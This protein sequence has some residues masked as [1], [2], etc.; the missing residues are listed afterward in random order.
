MN[1]IAVVYSSY[2]KDVVDGLL[3]GI[4]NNS[5]KIKLEIQ[6]ALVRLQNLDL[7][8]KKQ[9]NQNAQ[10]LERKKH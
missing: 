4:K 8:C 10:C 5:N 9:C 6:K 2:Y 3:D 7:I 1:K